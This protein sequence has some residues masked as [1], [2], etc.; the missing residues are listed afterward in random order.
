MAN[1]EEQFTIWAKG[2]S[3]T[4]QAKCENAETA[5]RKAIAAHGKLSAM[6]V[7]VFAQ[8]SYRNRTN[9]RQD[10][11]VDICVR[12]NSTFFPNYPAGKTKKDFGNTDGSITF[13]DYKDLVGEALVDYFGEKSVHRGNKAFDIHE[14]SY[15]VDSDVVAALEHRRY[16][17]KMNPDG[18]HEFLSGIEFR[19][20]NG[21]QIT[22]WPNQNYENGVAKHTATGKRFKKMIRILKQLRNSM[23]EEKAA[24]AKD[25]ASCLI[26]ALVW[27]VPNEGFG[28]DTYKSDVRYVLMHTFNKTIK[29]DD[30]KEWGEVNELK[31]L[32]RPS[33]PWTREQAH[34]FLSAAWDR[35]GF[36]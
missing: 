1:W 3:A 19:A 11:D 24:A 31:Y 2:P 10:S 17:G 12:L 6:D 34:N 29:D 13:A 33:Q 14:N 20:D 26:E 30:C 18:S 35:I 7:S 21:A 5:I 23:Q 15:R 36:E 4:E 16:T 9:V 28:H 32:F 25:V 8:G 27:N 22:N